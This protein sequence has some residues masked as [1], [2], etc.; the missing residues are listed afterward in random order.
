MWLFLRQQSAPSAWL[1]GG[2]R[3]RISSDHRTEVWLY[4]GARSR[5]SSDHRTEVRAGE[6]F[7]ASLASSGSW[8]AGA[9]V[10]RWRQSSET[11][12]PRAHGGAGGGTA[13]VAG[14]EPPWRAAAACDSSP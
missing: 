14:G 6:E 4:G 3:S 8:Q 10:S 5:I 13:A 11:P 7:V 2:A 9:Q 12:A 1:Y